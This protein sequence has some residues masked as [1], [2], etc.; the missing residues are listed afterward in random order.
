MLN[1]LKYN[2]LGRKFD[3]F[4]IDNTMSLQTLIWMFTISFFLF[5]IDRFQIVFGYMSLLFGFW[6]NERAVD[7]Q[8]EWNL[9]RDNTMA[10]M[11]GS[12][13]LYEFTS[14]R[15]I[16]YT[17][18]D[19]GRLNRKLFNGKQGATVWACDNDGNPQKKLL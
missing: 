9:C 8:N 19:A 7:R 3:N 4:L 14:D 13:D 17:I 6:L 12:K 15:Q 1:P 16:I 5:H 18:I 10:R 11:K 2:V